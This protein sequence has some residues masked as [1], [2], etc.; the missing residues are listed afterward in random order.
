VAYPLETTI[1]LS[2]PLLVLVR[3][4]N[5]PFEPGAEH[6]QPSATISELVTLAGLARLSNLIGRQQEEIIKSAST[7]SEIRV[8]DIMVPVDQVTFMSAEQSPDDAIMAAYGDPHTRF[9]VC[10]AGDP[11]R[12]CGY[13]NLKELVFRARFNP[14]QRSIRPAVRELHYLDPDADCAA[15]LKTFVNEHIHIAIVREEGRSLGLVTLED[16]VEELVGEITDEFDRAPRMFHALSANRWMVG[17]GVPVNQLAM[18][19]GVAL[20]DAQGSVSR[21]LIDRLGGLPASKTIYEEAGLQFHVRRVRRGSIFEV[22]VE[23][24]EPPPGTPPS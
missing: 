19:L 9:P 8:R 16:L 15:A 2:S 4:I 23:K 7:L 5:R 21:W 18:R 22:A 11:D 13:V 10:E 1:K 12:L 3:W 14:D 17:G 6:K 20:P 24:V